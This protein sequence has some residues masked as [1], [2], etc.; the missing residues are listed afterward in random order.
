MSLSFDDELYLR[1]FDNDLGTCVGEK[2]LQFHVDNFSGTGSQTSF[3][4]SQTPSATYMVLVALAGVFQT[5]ELAS[6]SGTTL[7]F[8]TAPGNGVAVQ[9]TYCH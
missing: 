9:V 8:V 5:S 2:S 1:S 4:L 6:V 3:T 7:T